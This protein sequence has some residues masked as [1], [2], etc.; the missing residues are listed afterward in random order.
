MA[1]SLSQVTRLRLLQRSTEVHVL[2]IHASYSLVSHPHTVP[3]NTI[4]ETVRLWLQEGLNGQ[5]FERVVFAASSCHELIEKCMHMYFPTPVAATDAN[6]VPS[7]DLVGQSRDRERER[8][9]W[10]SSDIAPGSEMLSGEEGTSDG[11]DRPASKSENAGLQEEEGKTVDSPQT[12][13]V[14][15]EE[16]VQKQSRKAVPEPLQPV[17][18]P[19]DASQQPI[20]SAID[21]I[22]RPPKPEG[23]NESK[24]WSTPMT[25]QSIPYPSPRQSQPARPVGIPAWEGTRSPLDDIIMQLE[26]EG[27]AQ[28]KDKL[29]REKTE[30]TVKARPAEHAEGGETT[31]TTVEDLEEMIMGLQVLSDDL[32][33]ASSEAAREHSKRSSSQLHETPSEN[34]L[35]ESENTTRH[36]PDTTTHIL[37]PSRIESDV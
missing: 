25:V 5:K 26:K 13:K 32:E 35:S 27:G 3:P 4:V 16:T 20:K 33:Q 17:E 6:S 21:V 19:Q 7:S 11:P 15:R 28:G 14:N 36:T 12:T 30:K 18:E 1:S 34:K 10:T 2:S 31:N 23:E 9:S 24:R 37:N 29:K 22:V 8:E